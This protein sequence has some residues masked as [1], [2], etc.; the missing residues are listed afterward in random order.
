MKIIFTLVWV[1]S[2]IYL[3]AQTQSKV[4]VLEFVEILDGQ[5]EEAMYYYENNWKRLREIAIKRGDIDDFKI[6]MDSSDSSSIKL[7]LY[8]EFPGKYALE[9]SEERFGHIIQEVSSKGPKL[10][11]DIPPSEFRK[12]IDTKIL[13]VH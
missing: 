8:T 11:N 10:L 1:I 6:M 13:E 7:Y 3:Q 2:S 9:K 5:I 4:A 12:N